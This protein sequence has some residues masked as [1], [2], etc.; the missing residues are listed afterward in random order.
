V[1]DA[2]AIIGVT[3]V[4]TSGFLGPLVLHHA[5]KD[6]DSL[7]DMREALDSA[8]EP[9]A[10]ARAQTFWIE[11]YAFGK[12]VGQQEIERRIEEVLHQ[13]HL[14]DAHAAKLKLRFPNDALS[15]AYGDATDAANEKMS[16][17]WRRRAGE[18]AL[19]EDYKKEMNAAEQA[20]A[21]A[22][23]AFLEAATRWHRERHW[24]YRSV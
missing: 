16:I 19:I 22:F 24:P 6:R 14:V 18:I 23:D 11:A 8:I 4:L 10:S 20:F 21:E 15:G 9:L 7:S 2:A 13:L 12:A 3:A 5:Q 17:V 1:A